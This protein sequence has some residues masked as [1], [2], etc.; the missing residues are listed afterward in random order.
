MCDFGVSFSVSLFSFLSDGIETGFF[1][2]LLILIPIKACNS[3]Q[4]TAK[5]A[6]E[7]IIIRTIAIRAQC[8]FQILENTDREPI[9]F[10]RNVFE[11]KQLIG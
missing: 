7:I 2:P 4:A 9:N 10:N 5:T 8:P 11:F 1:Y 6:T 3:Y